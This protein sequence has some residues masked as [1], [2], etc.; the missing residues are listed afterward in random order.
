M[1]SFAGCSGDDGSASGDTD[2]GTSDTGATGDTDTAGQSVDDYLWETWGI[3]LLNFDDDG[4]FDVDENDVQV[5]MNDGTIEVEGL[6]TWEIATTSVVDPVAMGGT[7]SIF[8]SNADLSEERY[9]LY[10]PVEGYITIGDFT[11]GVAV[12]KNPD[13]TYDVWAFDGD[14]MDTTTT[15]DNGFEA[16]K[17]VEQYNDFTQISPYILLTAFAA[18]HIPTPEPRCTSYQEGYQQKEPDWRAATP[19]VCEIFQE[20]CDCAACL[21]LDRQGACA[22]CPPL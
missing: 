22:P 9:F 21:V 7:T 4:Y 18:A 16:L 13:G 15:V 11:K 1:T 5:F 19:P 8:V 3:R 14:A 6:G 20:F 2:G 17:L 12:S 10:D